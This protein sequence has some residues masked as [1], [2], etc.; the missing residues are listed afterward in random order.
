M[1][2]SSCTKDGSIKGSSLDLAA[3][4]QGAIIPTRAPIIP[5]LDIFGACHYRSNL[6]GDFF[7]YFD[8]EE[9]CCR[10]DKRLRLIIGDAAGHG[11][12]AALVMVTARAYLRE[13]AVQPGKINEVITDVNKRLVRDAY[14]TGHFMTAFCLDVSM[15]ENT[16]SWVR[17]GHP[18]ALLFDCKTGLFE[19][20][21]GNGIPLGV[22]PGHAYTINSREALRPGQLLVIGTDG[23]WETMNKEGQLF[24]M[25]RLR[26]I[27]M[28][29][30]EGTMQ[31][32]TESVFSSLRSFSEQDELQDDATIVAIKAKSDW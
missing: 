20:L 2:N 18:P 28:S 25:E 10:S 5:G 23:I 19:Q 30:S 22:D 16:L 24:G 26:H 32:L 31:R 1:K 13:R 7:D 9:A 12:A 17:A 8:F 21:S 11:V 6:G 29:N 3:S 15:S 14:Q 27:I 4:F